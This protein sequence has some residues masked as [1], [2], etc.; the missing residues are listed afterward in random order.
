MPAACCSALEPAGPTLHLNPAP[1]S[2][3][4][5]QVGRLYGFQAYNLSNEVYGT[6]PINFNT[7]AE[8]KAKGATMPLAGAFGFAHLSALANLSLVIACLYC[9]PFSQ[10]LR[11]H[12]VAA[13]WGDASLVLRV[14]CSWNSPQPCQGPCRALPT[15]KLCAP[16]I[17][18]VFRMRRGPLGVPAGQPVCSHHGAL[19]ANPCW[20]S[21]RHQQQHCPHEQCPKG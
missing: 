5:P 21:L 4:L 19:G 8:P 9:V 15:H 17:N 12:L 1:E 10:P 13:A 6:S 18:Y 20:L 3:S 14:L 11:I 2:P 7:E 16:T